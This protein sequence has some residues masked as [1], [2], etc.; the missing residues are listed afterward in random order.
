LTVDIFIL[1]KKC[2][3]VLEIKQSHV[4]VKKSRICIVKGLHS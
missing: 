2:S 4:V 3:L 1:I